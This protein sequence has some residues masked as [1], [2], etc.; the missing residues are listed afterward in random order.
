MSRAAVRPPPGM[1]M[2]SRQMSGSCCSASRMASSADAPSATTSTSGTSASDATTPA[3]N[4]GWSSTTTSRIVSVGLSHIGHLTVTSRAAASHRRRPRS[5]RPRSS[6]CSRMPASPRWPSAP[7]RSGRSPGPPS[8]TVTRSQPFSRDHPD[9]DV[10][11]P[12]R[13]GWRS[14]AAPAARG[15][16]RSWSAAARRGR[17]VSS[18]S[19]VTCVPLCRT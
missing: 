10:A 2:S 3:R 4:I 12:R 11:R 9:A 7:T 15:R 17:R 16:A 13:A 18:M 6:A 8:E 14:T 1:A 19:S 5:R